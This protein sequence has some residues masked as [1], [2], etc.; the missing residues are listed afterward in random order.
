VPAIQ[1]ALHAGASAIFTV[2]GETFQL[3][4]RTFYLNTGV[5]GVGGGSLRVAELLGCISAD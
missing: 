5:W 1:E 4:R 3:T 2:D